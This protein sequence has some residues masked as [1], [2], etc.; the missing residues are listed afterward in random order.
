MPTNGRRTDRPNTASTATHMRISTGSWPTPRRRARGCRHSSRVWDTRNST[1][2]IR[3]SRE[4]LLSSMVDVAGSGR[5]T[6][7]T[8]GPD[9]AIVRKE[10]EGQGSSTDDRPRQVRHRLDWCRSSAGMPHSLTTALFDG[11]G[12]AR[13]F[14]IISLSVKPIPP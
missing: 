8:G 9:R 10:F 3:L 5:P 4:A 12:V 7:P 11:K 14:L 6:S 13:C 1:P 2:Y